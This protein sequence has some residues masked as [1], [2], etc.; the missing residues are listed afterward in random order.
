LVV[1]NDYKSAPEATFPLVVRVDGRIRMHHGKNVKCS[2]KEW[3]LIGQQDETTNL[4]L[5]PHAREGEF[6][7]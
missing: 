5:V 6:G 1:C 7:F 3:Y 4:Y 2:K